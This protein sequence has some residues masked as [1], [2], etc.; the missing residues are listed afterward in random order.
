MFGLLARTY[1]FVPL[2]AIVPLYLHVHIPLS[3]YVSTSASFLLL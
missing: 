2:D 1:L 3:V